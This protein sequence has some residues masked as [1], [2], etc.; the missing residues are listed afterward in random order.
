MSQAL[1][2]EAGVRILILN[3]GGN[4]PADQSE[5]KLTF[6]DLMERNLKSLQQGLECA[7]P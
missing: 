6:L 1:A 2:K 3:P 5:Q 4:L 7:S